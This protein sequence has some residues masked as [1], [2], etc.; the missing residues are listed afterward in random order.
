MSHANIP[1][2]MKAKPM[3]IAGTMNASAPQN[4]MK[5]R[6]RL[7]AS[8]RFPT[9]SCLANPLAPVSSKPC[10]RPM[11]AMLEAHGGT[12]SLLS[13]DSGAKFLFLLPLTG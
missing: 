3:T 1:K 7:S 6:W 13:S 5:P 8:Q 2:N 12:I 4:F 9:G 10:W 11:K